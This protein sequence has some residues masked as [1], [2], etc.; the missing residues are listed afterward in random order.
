MQ[1]DVIYAPSTSAYSGKEIENKKIKDLEAQVAGLQ[2]EL[3][4]SRGEAESLKK[5]KV[6]YL[7]RADGENIK[8]TEIIAV[9]I[10]AGLIGLA[11]TGLVLYFSSGYFKI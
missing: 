2:S 6:T 10:L 5:K 4:M 1:L 7:L 11:G 9:K 3:E 8:E